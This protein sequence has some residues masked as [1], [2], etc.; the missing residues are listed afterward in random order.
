MN[1]TNPYKILESQGRVHL[2]TM[3]DKFLIPICSP[4]QSSI[5]LSALGDLDT[6]EAISL[7]VSE[8]NKHPDSII[9]ILL[10]EAEAFQAVELQKLLPI[11]NQAIRQHN[12]PASIF[13]WCCTAAPTKENVDIWYQCSKTYI[14]YDI[15]VL[16]YNFWAVMVAWHHFDDQRGCWLP[17]IT[18]HIS[19]RGKLLLSYNHAIRPH[20]VALISL[21]ANRSFFNQCLISL[22]S[23]RMTT[24]MFDYV[25]REMLKDVYPCLHDEIMSGVEKLS[26][27]I[28]LSYDTSPNDWN[29][30]WQV[31]LNEQNQVYLLVINET[32]GIANNHDYNLDSSYSCTFLTEKTYKGLVS[33]QPFILN[34]TPGALAALREQGFR[35]FSPYID[36]SYD[37]ILD[38]DSRMKAI[39]SE[40]DRLSTLTDE[41]W[42]N[43]YANLYD[44]FVH[45][46]DLVFRL[47]DSCPFSYDW[48][49]RGERR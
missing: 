18:K 22:G 5:V 39:L 33:A 8:Y 13:L 49:I 4:Y 14:S 31:N 32:L 25:N 24:N 34:T 9:V 27:P 36:E 12:I 29:F 26:F 10:S 7:I 38:D 17:E 20:R 30:L 44:V 2:G 42:I 46:R 21:L 37:G 1:T 11:A 48:Y 28:T 6:T 43:M 23:D 47:G 35:T 15:S 45:N 16:F 19:P 41:Q 3:H 40:I